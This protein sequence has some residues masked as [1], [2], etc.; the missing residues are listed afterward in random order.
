MGRLNLP[1]MKHMNEYVKVT[2]HIYGRT[3]YPQP[4]EYVKSVTVASGEKPEVPEGQNW[5][6]VIAIPQAAI[7][8][9]IP[10]MKEKAP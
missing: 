1:G 6:E 5:V 2:Y 7:V 3:S 9:V 8:Q 10:R 4:L